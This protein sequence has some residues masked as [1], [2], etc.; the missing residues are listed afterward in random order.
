MT[1][2]SMTLL[3]VANV[4]IKKKYTFECNIYKIT[5]PKTIPTMAS[6]NPL[7]SPA[8]TGLNAFTR[9]LTDADLKSCVNVESSFVEHERCSEEKVPNPLT[10]ININ[11]AYLIIYIS[12]TGS[13]KPPNSAS[14]SLSKQMTRNNSSR[15]SLLFD[16]SR[17]R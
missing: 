4:Y 17:Q 6:T 5:Q 2:N 14:V 10:P 8:L 1:P 7:Q 3:Q 11:I 16:P 15:M 12:H 9:P 13:T